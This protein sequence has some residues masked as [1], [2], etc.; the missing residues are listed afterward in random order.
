MAANSLGYAGAMTPMQ[1]IRLRSVALAVLLVPSAFAVQRVSE[2]L[3][4]PRHVGLPIWATFYT[5]LVALFLG[6]VLA[7][8]IGNRKA[9][10]LGLVMLTAG[11][12]VYA[13]VVYVVLPQAVIAAKESARPKQ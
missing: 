9:L 3:N 11:V 7:R 12:G 10:Q 8:L 6:P 13:Y 2:A 5:A 4:I 1:L